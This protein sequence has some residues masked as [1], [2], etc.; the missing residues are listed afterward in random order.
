VAQIHAY[1]FAV[2]PGP[3][4]QIAHLHMGG[5]HCAAKCTN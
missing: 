3:N 4:F 2:N 5:S 1:S